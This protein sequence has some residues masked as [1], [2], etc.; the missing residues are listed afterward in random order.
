VITGGALI[1]TGVFIAFALADIASMRQLGIGLTVAVLLDATLVRL[2]LLP[3]AIRLCGEASWW[4]PGW[5]RRVLPE[6]RI[7]GVATGRSGGGEVRGAP[8]A[9]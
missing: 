3:A 5:L 6:P 7:E 2:V 9:G 8:G 4:L 1:M